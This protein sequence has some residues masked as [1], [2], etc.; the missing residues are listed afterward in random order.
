MDE[1]YCGSLPKGSFPVPA[2]QQA[3]GAALPAFKGEKEF[4]KVYAFRHC[5]HPEDA[6]RSHCIHGSENEIASFH[7]Q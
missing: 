1:N 6:W 2:C 4:R 5:E 7:S 3:G